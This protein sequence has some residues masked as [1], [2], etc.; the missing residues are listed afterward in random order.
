MKTKTKVRNNYVNREEIVAILLRSIMMNVRLRILARVRY[1]QRPPTIFGSSHIYQ[2]LTD[3]SHIEAV[4]SLSLYFRY[5][6]R[7]WSAI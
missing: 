7:N 5:L 6:M 4:I 2:S 3:P 1:L